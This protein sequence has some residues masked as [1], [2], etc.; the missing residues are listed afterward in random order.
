MSRTLVAPPRQAPSAI[1]TPSG[2]RS[3]ASASTSV[4]VC[5]A[6]AAVLEPGA[7]VTSSPRARAA[8]RSTS[9][10]PTPCRAT[11]RNRG[12]ASIAAALTAPWRVRMAS[13]CTSAVRAA[14]ASADG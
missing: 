5:S 1:A 14:T 8:A 2:R 7:R 4:S 12:E 3:L 10:T 13:A 11:M 6:T 9:S